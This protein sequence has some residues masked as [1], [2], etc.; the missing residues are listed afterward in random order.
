[1]NLRCTVKATLWQIATIKLYEMV[2]SIKEWNSWPENSLLSC[3][4]DT[5]TAQE[6]A[7]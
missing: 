6:K 1:M 2:C 3:T 7:K 4:S 5:L